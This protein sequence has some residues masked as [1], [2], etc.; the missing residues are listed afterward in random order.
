[1]NRRDR[2]QQKGTRIW[3][4]LLAS[5][6]LFTACGSQGA[7]GTGSDKGSIISDENAPVETMDGLVWFSQK[8]ELESLSHEA[9]FIGW[10]QGMAITEDYA[11]YL[12]QT[13]ND[14]EKELTI[15]RVALDEAFS[16]DI[17]TGNYPIFPAV[18]IT[19]Q[20]SMPTQV[21]MQAD[22]ERLEFFLRFF[23]DEAGHLYFVSATNNK[24]ISE[25]HVYLYRCDG[26]GEILEK[27]DVTEVLSDFV[28]ETVFSSAGS[29]DTYDSAVDREG[30][31]YLARR[32]MQMLWILN[33]D[34]SLLH[35]LTLPQAE[36]QR[37][38]TVGDGKVYMIT[39]EAAASQLWL[40][41]VQ[42]GEFVLLM[43]LTDTKGNGF[44]VAGGTDKLLYGDAEVLYECD[45]DAK[46]LEKVLTWEEY[47]VSGKNIVQ[48]RKTADGRY[49]TVEDDYHLTLMEQVDGS[50]LPA[51]KEQVVLG[52]VNPTDYMKNAVVE[53]NKRNAYY[54]VVIKEYRYDDGQQMLESELATGKGPDL[55]EMKRVYVEK[56]VN[57]NLIA[58]LSP[59]L[60]DGKGIER[61][62]LV[63]IVLEL[64]TI[65]GVLTCVPHAFSIDIMRGKEDII[66]GN[67]AW[68]V[69]EFL[70]CL[71][72]Q[73]G[74]QVAGGTTFN[75]SDIGN[76]WTILYTVLMT[77]IDYFIDEENQKA[78]FD[79][80]EFVELLTFAKSYRTDPYDYAKYTEPNL[81]VQEGAMLL[82]NSTIGS[83]D[84]Y[85][86]ANAYLQQEGQFVGYPTYDG[87]SAYGIRVDN[88]YGVNAN[89]A[90]KDGA[91]AFIEFMMTYRYEGVFYGSG[92]KLSTLK[93][94]L[95]HDLLVS[96]YKLYEKDAQYDVLRDEKGNPVEAPK[97]TER[98]Q[99][100]KV[101]VEAYAA[102]QEDI[103][104]LW[105][106]INGATFIN[107]IYSNAI[108][109]ILEEECLIC[110]NGDRTVE[111]TVN[112][113][114]SRVQ[115]YLD[116]QN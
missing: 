99:N 92:S 107:D 34:G 26:I 61:D 19:E 66:G 106:L 32:D 109:Q 82:I 108:Y 4:L 51:Q 90:V 39:G 22:A 116:E 21:L 76:Q 29:M 7:E 10:F 30:R 103:D 57:K 14:F 35:K 80:K 65:D 101:V 31:I 40:I 70:D 18:E 6:L 54:E 60:E 50:R 42:T 62:D 68:T 86:L 105:E 25:R 64:N 102:T 83:M 16:T 94:E 46:S 77:N 20:Y 17:T 15:N 43:D 11:Y 23:T 115:L 27:I 48:A 49:Y 78:L 79:S 69:E 91:W 112:I 47:G 59:Y 95:E 74:V 56:L 44:F 37:M 110:L 71:K 73:E 85:M 81:Q 3:I 63:D 111:E 55:F 8:Q 28:P 84:S 1:M 72:E 53:F 93:A 41:D 87:K 88:S 24:E 2:M 89:S 75:T 13:T 98:D 9:G 113:I 33:V 36:L 96:T 38:Q 45:I 97:W 114:Q 12:Y 100:G 104:A 52:M 5:I 58:D 67:S